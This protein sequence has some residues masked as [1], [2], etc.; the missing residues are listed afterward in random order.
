MTQI[1]I[2][3]YMSFLCIILWKYIYFLVEEKKEKTLTSIRNA[4]N[5]IRTDI[6]VLKERLKLAKET[7]TKFKDE[8][9]RLQAQQGT[10]GYSVWRKHSL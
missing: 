4:K 3:F 6:T 7:I 2:V 8:I 5:K 1:V 10:P 9:A